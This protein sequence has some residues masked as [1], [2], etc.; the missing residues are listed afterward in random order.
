MK[1][2]ASFFLA[3]IALSSA[4]L[5]QNP[6]ILSPGGAQF[7]I[8]RA[9]SSYDLVWDTTTTTQGQRFRF[10]FGTSVSGP[11]TDLTGATNVLDSN[12]SSTNRRGRF[13]GG[14]RAPSLQTLTGYIRMVL[15]SDTTRFGISTNPIVVERPTP[16]KIDSVLS[17]TITNNLFLSNQKIYGLKGYVHVVSPA[18]LT[19]QAGTIIVGDTVG[20]NSALVINRGAKIIANGTA[21][22]PIVMTSSAPP[23]ER[24][25]G[26]W[27]GLLIYGKAR[28]NNPGGEAAQEGGVADPLDKTKWYYGGTDDNDNS[29]SLQYV[30]VEFGGIALQ[31][32]QELNGITMGGVGRGTTMR[33]VQV[34]YAND[35]GFE[36]FGGSVD[37]KYL[38]S[39]GALDDDFDTDNGFSGRIQYGIAQRYTTRADQ[40]TSQ[41]FEA[42]NDATATYNQP[43]SSA[44]FSNI[45]AIG[46]LADTSF[47]PNARFGA[48]A[49]IRRNTRQ[50]IYNSAFI[51]WPRGIEIAQTPTMNAAN[52]DSVHIRNNAWYGVKGT[53]L[54]LAGGTAPSGFDANWIAKAAYSNVLEKGST[55]AAGIDNPFSDVTFNP[56]LKQGSPLLT[57]ANFTR[58]GVIA[59][60]DAFFDKVEFRG[61]MGST[62]WDLP[63]ANYDPI[64]TTYKAQEPPKPLITTPGGA[65][66]EIY[67]AGISYDLKWD[68]TTTTLGATYKFQYGT[69]KTGPWTDLAGATSV[70][71]SNVSSTVKRGLFVG[72]F[73]TPSIQ[74]T[75]L[76]IRMINLADTNL[77]GVSNN[78][79]SV[80]RPLPTT[81]DSVLTGTITSNV[82]LS[83]TKIYG[84]RGFVHVVSPA[85]LTIQPGTVIVGDTVGN[86][87]ALI[88]NRGAKIIANG[89]PTLPIVFT[90]SAPAGQRRSGDWGGLL[91]YGRAKINN[92]GFE[93]AQEGG[94]ANANDK[95]KWYYGGAFDDD[96]SG[97]LRYVRVEFGGIALQPNQELNGLTLG[98]VGSGTTIENVQVSYAND[99]GIEWFGGNVNAKRLIVVNSLDDD[100]DTD[101]GFSGKIQFAVSQ[102]FKA[103][104]DQSTSQAFESDNDATATYNSP[105]TSAIF[106]NVT[107]IGP[108]S[109]ITTT[110][111]AR[112][113]AAVQIRR[114]SRQSIFNSVFMGWPRGIEIAQVP[115]MNAALADTFQI[116]NNMWFGVK[117]TWM[118]TAGG[119]APAGFDANW[120]TKP[121]FGNTIDKDNANGASLENPFS[122]DATFNAL[123]KTGSPVLTGASF[124]KNGIV[125]IDDA[126]FEKVTYK[127]AFGAQ[128]WDLPWANYDPVNTNYKAQTPK[129]P[130][131]MLSPG[132]KANE[133]YRAGSSYDITWDTTASALGSRYKFQFGT[134]SSGPWTDLIGATNVLDSNASSTVKRGKFV[135][136]FRAPAIPT[137]SGY[138]RMVLI[139]DTTV[140]A[141]STNPFTIDRPSASKV[142]SVLIGTISSNLKLSN[143][144]I[145]GLRGYVHV[146]E[147]AIL[148]IEPGTII[149]GDSVG[150]NS[151][152]IINRGAKIIANGTPTLPI[153]MTSSAP[154]GQ[155]R[156]GDW[157]GLLIYGKAR[158][159][160]PGGEAAQEG[161]V[162]N[163]NDK[164]KWYYG[165]T[166]DN[167]NS[168][169]LQ[170]V[171]VEFGG[172]ALQPNQELNGITMGGVG[173]GTTFNNIQVSHS[174]D[175][176]FEWFG[177]SMDAKYL[178]STAALDDDFDT[179]NGFSGRI[180]FG[181]SQRFKSRADQSTSQ[182][183][184]SD[185]DA[186]A[187]YNQPNTSAIFSNITA[188]GP[189]ADTAN[190]PNARF[191]AA[192]QIR[193][194]SRQSIFN[195]V[196]AGWPRGIE[197]AQV[198]TMNAALA[199]SLQIRNNSWYGVKGTGLN[200]A[201]GTPP[202]GIDANWIAKPEFGNVLDRSTPNNAM[203]ENAFAEDVT[204][205]PVP[206]SGS[207]LLGTASFTKNGIVAIDDAYFEKVT[208]RGAMGLQRWDLPW[209]NYDPINTDYKAQS[210]SSVDEGSVKGGLSL[211]V[212]PNPA[213]DRVRVVY[214]ITQTSHVSIR[215]YN[216]S[217]SLNAD[218]I[219]NQSQNPGIYEF[220]IDTQDIA[221]GMYY[222]QIITDQGVSTETIS[223]IR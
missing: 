23:G 146:V 58:N 9:G 123:P 89:T 148:T 35:D 176:A 52:A 184:E 112:F 217:G 47:T 39:V 130:L 17:G 191:G 87:S 211:N 188:I 187:T 86:N 95:T 214:E 106:S 12:A 69:S 173:R 215:L 207:P 164:T 193:R 158:I 10:Q 203:L 167:D 27:G 85:T 41:A 141:V 30:R 135:G 75:S 44:I 29:G 102:R 213:I 64:N 111:N 81:V 183:F 84:L 175:D 38:I 68:T 153:V 181:V 45:T 28:I 46:P 54:N 152:L 90:S 42:D 51:G 56:S 88:I 114:N 66:G 204:F 71:D 93:A 67:R 125:G 109:D 74:T 131:T 219:G 20:V 98:G 197:I 99:D 32:N 223:I 80:E 138:L 72:G 59:I 49:Q 205:N 7:E 210:P 189:L 26:D 124:T 157:G 33:Y 198:P 119:T 62:R 142:D 133:N 156:G 166:D 113:G 140:T 212:T 22:L 5:A 132:G 78:P 83:N 34:S 15:I 206:K 16:T 48:A 105:N 61:A 76:Y 143:T 129:A 110:P 208:Y 147:P 37:A 92:P 149:L 36:W 161:G 128:R 139:A 160:N 126:F 180:Q 13:I 192:A 14:F 220:F 8:Y 222:M 182:A 60:D 117:N 57:G 177:G 155:R 40:S 194:N 97:I 171:R 100:F 179:D 209:A 94:V 82:Y 137:T 104:A 136:G 25:A 163:A 70:K 96:N 168:G 221:S 107:A 145:Y 63:W 178:I 1:H 190:S 2:I 121:E 50:A 186:T 11:W 200:L 172:I 120:I 73:R 216:A 55:T 53:W 201:G 134:S 150:N 19:I 101:N 185:N 202:A 151:A 18:T 144:K 65:A 115:T 159:N 4:I 218:F 116:R 195:S 108:L 3:I 91:I 154:P 118:N 199:D 31:P 127:G 6:K 77:A 196:F 165:G 174:N 103:R 21:T 169:S 162:A 122:E 170:Y 79:I 24:R 43:Y